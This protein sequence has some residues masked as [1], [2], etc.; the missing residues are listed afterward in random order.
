[1]G[2]PDFGASGTD[3]TAGELLI[4]YA[5][6]EEVGPQVRKLG[7]RIRVTGM[8]AR[9]AEKSFRQELAA[10]RPG[11][12]LTC[13][14]AGGLNPSLALGDIVYSADAELQMD[15]AMRQLG[16]LAARFRT[17]PQVV[18]KSEEKLL[19][20]QLTGNDAVEMES[21]HIRAICRQEGIPSATIR[22]ILDVAGED[23]PVDF[24]EFLTARQNLNYAKL[25]WAI[26]RRPSLVKG[27]RRLQRDS[28]IARARLD[29][30]LASL[31]RPRG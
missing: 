17:T 27:L 14:F 20:R 21:S 24:N 30:A 31:L 4:C 15:E 1:M 22:V 10:R 11:V 23:L 3:Q 7:A 29:D 13:G 25:I 8:G 9:N 18:A 19:L 26:L 28:G 5:V 16:A 6:K 2:E 12:V